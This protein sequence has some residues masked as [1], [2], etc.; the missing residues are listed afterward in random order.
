MRLKFPRCIELDT[1][2]K[3]II[4]NT[5]L[6]NRN[7]THIGVIQNVQGVRTANHLVD[8]DEISFDVYQTLDGVPCALWNQIQDFMLV[9]V[10]SYEIWYETRVS[11]DEDNKS[12]KHVECIQAQQAE[13][14][15]LSLHEVEINT[16]DDIARDDYTE[17]K[18]YNPENPSASILNRILADKAPHYSIYHVD[19]SLKDIVR[20]F[21]FDGTYITDALQEIAEEVNCLFVFGEHDGHDNEIHR[22]IS[23]YDMSVVCLDCGTRD[24]IDDECPK[25]HSTNLAPAYG[26]YTNL[27][28]SVENFTDRITYSTN[29][30]EVKNC[31]RLSGGDE[32][33]DAAIVSCNPSG[34]NY[35]WMFSDQMYAQMSDEL[36]SKLEE[37]LTDS[38]SYQN[39]HV[40]EIPASDVTAYNNLVT[41][42]RE[43]DE[44]L[45]MLP[46]TI[47][48]HT[49]LIS[50][51][52][53]A[54]DLQS[55][56]QTSL[57]PDAD[58]AEDTTAE[59]EAAK[60]TVANLSPIGVKKLE[61][62]SVYTADSSVIN[63]AKVYVDTSRY[64]ISVVT[65]T[66]ANNVWTGQLQLESYT[67]EDDT[68][69]TDML[70]I[71]FNGN[72]ADYTKQL[73]EKALAKHETDQV[74]IVELFSMEY[75]DFC[76]AIKHYSRDGLMDLESIA[77]ACLDVLASEGVGESS[78]ALYNT[79]YLP[80][81][82]KSLAIDDELALRID[83]IEIL[84]ELTGDELTGGLLYEIENM[85]RTTRN[86]L[87]M[88]TYL[89]E[90]LWVEFCSFR[91]DG[92]YSNE[93]FISDGLTSAEVIERAREY[94]NAARRE[95]H[96]AANAQHTVECDLYDLLLLSPD[97]AE[98][99]DMFQVGNYIQLQVDGKVYR[100]RLT[101][102]E[103]D[104]DDLESIAVTFADFCDKNDL[105]SET[106][107]ILK[108]AKSMSTAFGAVLKQASK[109]DQ[110]NNKLKK[111]EQLG[112]SLTAQK[113]VNDA[114]QQDLVLDANGLLA[115][116]YDDITDDYYPGQTKIINDG[117][118]YTTDNWRTVSAGLGRFIY[119][120]PETLENVE[121]YGIIAKTIVGNI[122]IGE[123]V[124]IYNADA[125]FKIDGDGLT[126]SE[127]ATSTTISQIRPDGTF[128]LAGRITWDG[129]SLVIGTASGRNLYLD[130]SNLRFRYAT[131]V[132]LDLTTTGMTLYDYSGTQIASFGSYNI[133]MGTTTNN[134]T[135]G[136]SKISL[137]NDSI[138]VGSV[139]FGYYSQ[140]SNLFGITLSLNRA[141][142]TKKPAYAGIVANDAAGDS[143]F[144]F[145]YL[146]DNASISGYRSGALNAGCDLDMNGNYLYDLN[147]LYLGDGNTSKYLG[148]NT[149]GS[150][151]STAPIMVNTDTHYTG[152]ALFSNGNMGCTGYMFVGNTNH[153]SSGSYKLDVNGN[154]Y[155][156]GSLTMT[157]AL[158]VSGAGA[159]NGNLT[160]GGSI[161]DPWI[162]GSIN[163]S[164]TI[165]L[166][167]DGGG[168]TVYFTTAGN[169]RKDVDDDGSIGTSSYR[170]TTIYAKNGTIN[171]SDR[172]QKD[173]IE[174]I[175]FAYDLIM[176]LNPVTYMWKSGDHRRKHMGFIAQEASNVCKEIDENL[177]FVT[178]SYKAPEGKDEPDV[179]YFGEEVDDELLN[180]GMIKQE[181]IA[182]MIKVIQMQ[183]TRLKD[184][185]TTIQ[186]LKQGG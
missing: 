37:Y 22:T 80:Y 13:L 129:T 71:T 66:Y 30:D 123:Q 43:Y 148:W 56:L 145:I 96:K 92:D 12:V 185:E 107:N 111:F 99:L 131:T 180:W 102:Y 179:D 153:A 85:I 98:I 176:S 182:P 93:N 154:S 64:K 18:F 83:E 16:E 124:K 54:M 46:E 163:S 75:A 58:A 122:M 73:V 108:S 109:G 144:K 47:T 105:V 170:W 178:A 10:P 137:T 147:R 41:K 89:G 103:I 173:N 91:R 127:S 57:M 39:D 150:F 6:A 49:E 184:L 168:E 177:A 81:Y 45:P 142:T 149:N 52:Y 135:V 24:V 151:I 183:E 28:V 70:N 169:F 95:L 156:A 157:G 51:Y 106:Q 138:A 128:D 112:F 146:Q 172:K 174:D 134:I 60:L 59:L 181:L 143:Y 160:V 33:M 36:R 34:D 94:Y 27:F 155:I 133:V 119:T 5:V 87:N 84:S 78:H 132:L 90:D 126:I 118:Y 69:T 100:L 88:H 67:D 53:S 1:D 44:E 50:A 31:L 32:V 61:N 26:D 25:C 167:A 140:N 8:A 171:T 104:Y 117:I 72:A 130:N 15:Q 152:Y 114:T 186:M 62:T 161:V 42:Y 159:I 113:I 14:S 23:A 68:A 164:G 110:A 9:Y 139:G 17:A 158:S 115:R 55:Y 121:D 2:N 162:S 38:A 166:N 4:P 74:G 120:D 65:S 63:Y 19:D 97:N 141:T 125:S 29:T 35:I 101:D 48:G 175:N 82:N 76:T 79:L 165:T 21:S 20:E 77:D 116:R 7:S 86:T 11:I 3:P 136:S 40:Y